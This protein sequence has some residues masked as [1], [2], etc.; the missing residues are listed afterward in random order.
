MK[1]QLR[2]LIAEITHRCPLHCVY[3]SNP[4]EMQQRSA[5]LS[6]EDW[7]GI[8]RQAGEMGALQLHL[9]GG[10]PL[11]RADLAD[12]VRAGRAAGLYLNLITSGVGLDE[13]RLD[14]L[15]GVGL[16]HIQLSFQDVAEASANEFAGTR[17]HALKLR[18]AKMVRQRRV[19]FTLNIVVHRRNLDRLEE[20]IALAAESGAQRVEIAHVQYYGW[21][22]RNR[23]ALLPA[24]DQVQRSIEI[25]ETARQRLQGRL[26]IDFVL[27]DYYAK[28]PK[29]CMNG[30]GHQQMLIDPSGRA[31]PCHAAGALPGM[32]FSNATER[33]LR[34]IWEDS[35]AFNRFR[36]ESWMPEPCRT[37]DRRA[38]DFG[39]CRCQAFL[40][41][42]DAAATDPVCTLAPTH[43]LVENA[44]QH[45][46]NGSA[47]EESWSAAWV[48]RTDPAPAEK[49]TL[50][51]A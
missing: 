9:T 32:E 42:G 6:T 3:C 29:P 23:D 35:P 16:D 18:V 10:E 27:P 14:E 48:Y 8:F 46:N 5:E 41:T 50:R 43:Q 49:I 31:L 36:D 15:I 30:W 44:V 4:L 51:E 38:R 34:W 33:P 2:A 47:G 19:G 40:L 7:I 39:G 22:L 25:V 21:A 17:S 20:M 12:L 13:R 28:Y 1:Y 11:A 24:R 26:R 37:C 45:A